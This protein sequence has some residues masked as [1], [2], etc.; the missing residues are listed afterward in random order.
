MPAREERKD[1]AESRKLILRTAACLFDEHGV[2]GVSMHQIAKKAGVGQGTL[3]R[4][5]SH[6]GDLCLDVI[7]DFGDRFT[8]E[9]GRFLRENDRLSA[10]DKL[11][12]VLDSWIDA[13]EK[14]SEIITT[15]QAH[16]AMNPEPHRE[17]GFFHS[18]IYLFLRGT[19]ASLLSEIRESRPNVSAD[20]VLT[21][22]ALICSMAPPGHFH[23]K[24]E[25]GFTTEQ[26]KNNY[27]HMC[28]LPGLPG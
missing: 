7:K 4:R 3:Y 20:P 9:V 28:G 18:P 15:I 16:Q 14:K 8:E 1:A 27:R 11:G 2:Q 26:M 6:K 13:I 17:M 25:F 10:E 23:V 24:R 12:Y 21:A 19:I 22:H 5:Y